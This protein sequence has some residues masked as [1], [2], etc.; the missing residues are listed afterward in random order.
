[1]VLNAAD[2]PQAEQKTLAAALQDPGFC[3]QMLDA[4]PDVFR[5]P[6]SRRVWDALQQLTQAGQVIDHAAIETVLGHPW[7]ATPSAQYWP[8]LLDQRLRRQLDLLGR[9]LEK[10]HAGIAATAVA[11]RALQS[12]NQ[13]LTATQTGTLW[14]GPEAAQAGLQRLL[15]GDPH[16]LKTGIAQL[17]AAAAGWGP[18]DFLL[19][20]ARPSQGKTAL[21]LQWAWHTALSGHGVMFCSVEMSVAAIGLRLLSQALGQSKDWVKTHATDPAV[22]QVLHQLQQAPWHVLDANGASVAD[23]QAAVARA[24]LQGPRCDVVIVDYLQLL[25]PTATLSNREQEIARLTAALK[26]WARRDHRLIVVLTQLSRA[27]EQRA[28]RVPALADLRESG[29]QEQDADGVVLIYHDAPLQAQLIIAK[30]RN[31]P[32]G[33]IPVTWDGPT[34]QF[35]PR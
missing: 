30:N 31:G 10:P 22:Q 13:A 29:A 14:S 23:L 32:T 25:R 34:M 35:A 9:W 19:I 8:L 33:A 15:A 5:H 20:G 17:D 6:T 7:S 18:E 28:D 11:A 16:W 1:M 3:A 26:A 12:L 21:G 27:V 24:E 2:W 4:G